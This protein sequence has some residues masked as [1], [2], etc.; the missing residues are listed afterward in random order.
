MLSTSILSFSNNFAEEDNL[1]TSNSDISLN[2]SVNYLKAK[3]LGCI[4]CQPKSSIQKKGLSL[5]QQQILDLYADAQKKYF[6]NPYFCFKERGFHQVLE[7]CDY[8][9]V[10]GEKDPTAR[11]TLGINGSSNLRKEEKIVVTKVITPLS[12]IVLW[13]SLKFHSR[14]VKQ[15][16]KKYI[17]AAFIPLSCSSA[18]FKERSFTRLTMKQK[19]LINLTHPPLFL[20]VLRKVSSPKVFECHL[21]ACNSIEDVIT[22]SSQMFTIQQD[23]SKIGSLSLPLPGDMGSYSFSSLPCHISASSPVLFSPNNYLNEYSINERRCVT[24]FR[25]KSP[26]LSNQITT[27]SQRMK[28]SRFSY[29]DWNS[30]QCSSDLYKI[31]T[32]IRSFYNDSPIYSKVNT[33]K[34]HRPS[35]VKSLKHTKPF[36]VHEIDK[37][38]IS[39][40]F[41]TSANKL[42]QIASG[43]FTNANLSNPSFVSDQ[44]A[45]ASKYAEDEHHKN[46]TNSIQSSYSKNCPLCEKSQIRKA[47]SVKNIKSSHHKVDHRSSVHEKKPRVGQENE[48]LLYSKVSSRF[49]NG[50]KE[51]NT[52]QVSSSSPSSKGYVEINNYNGYIVKVKH[53]ESSD[54]SNPKMVI[55]KS[56]LLSSEDEDLSKSIPKISYPVNSRVARSAIEDTSLIQVDKGIQTFQDD[57][58]FN[59]THH[60][61]ATVSCTNG[62]PKHS[63]AQLEVHFLNAYFISVYVLKKD[64]I[65]NLN[66]EN[67]NRN[68]I[69]TLVIY[70]FQDLILLLLIKV[71]IKKVH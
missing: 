5:I 6:T 42:D 22:L 56:V 1:C 10:I 38:P 46:V 60:L 57:R 69:Q 71:Y 21:F 7:I 30:D 54:S 52:L 51:K 47:S 44:E 28:E 66:H 37:K 62:R 48:S 9:I 2:S 3:Y 67:E 12:N 24:N 55:S 32:P 49:K 50:V 58:K 25:S 17:G 33:K 20:C 8:G 13:A 34:I 70:I 43:I 16:G 14:L 39:V 68:L 64:L 11:T 26:T 4:L 61:T 40:R 15:K 36:I 23:F 29:I 53:D 65:L 45:R 41:T 27:D 35:Q 31:E 18:I 59:H 19:F 63:V